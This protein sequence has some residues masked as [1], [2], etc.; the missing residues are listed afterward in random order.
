L[1]YMFNHHNFKVQILIEAPGISYSITLCI[2][3]CFLDMICHF[4][5][6]G[7]CF[8]IESHDINQWTTTS[9]S[10]HSCYLGLCHGSSW[11]LSLKHTFVSLTFL[12]AT[13]L[14]WQC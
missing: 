12:P 6:K 11:F 8:G 5:M 3:A 13:S 9:V 10:W 2:S 7:T 14:V 4:L 1:H